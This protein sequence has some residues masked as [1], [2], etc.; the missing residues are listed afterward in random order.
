MPDCPYT[1]SVMVSRMNT[2]AVIEVRIDHFDT[3]AGYGESE[4]RLPAAS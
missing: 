3:A 2:P 1:D 4:L